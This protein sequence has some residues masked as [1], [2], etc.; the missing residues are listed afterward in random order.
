MPF[1]RFIQK[2]RDFYEHPQKFT[3]LLVF[4]VTELFLFAMID[5]GVLINIISTFVLFAAIVAVGYNRKTLRLALF[6]GGFAFIGLW[7]V[8]FIDSKDLVFDIAIAALVFRA[9]FEWIVIILILRKILEAKEITMDIIS[10]AITAYLLMGIAFAF[11]YSIAII[12]DPNSI[13]V[14]GAPI[15]IGNLFVTLLYYSFVTLTTLGYGDI[16]PVGQLVRTFAYLEAVFG[17]LYMA[18][19]VASFV[20]IHIAQ[21]QPNDSHI[22]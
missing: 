9:I 7:S 6:F 18:T 5:S 11:F 2:I 21:K 14:G 22:Q 15:Q 12:M 4:V 13:L 20:G 1:K 16:L 3:I 10:A 19:I 8:K 17:V